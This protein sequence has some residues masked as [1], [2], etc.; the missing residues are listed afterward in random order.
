MM[1]EEVQCSTTET[2][3]NVESWMS[4]MRENIRYNEGIHYGKGFVI[5]GLSGL[6]KLFLPSKSNVSS[7]FNCLNNGFFPFSPESVEL[8]LSDHQRTMRE[9][10]KLEDFLYRS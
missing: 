1:I 3:R 7:S 2:F 6:V 5:Y 10:N 4:W 8:N 9:I